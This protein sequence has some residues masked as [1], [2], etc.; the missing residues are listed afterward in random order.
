MAS[1]RGAEVLQAA[2]KVF[3]RHSYS[4]ASVQD[5]A[6]EL[7]MPKG[8]LYHYIKSKEDLLAKIFAWSRR[9]SED[10]MARVSAMEAAPLEK[11]KAFIEGY[12][13]WTVANLE[14]AVI[15]AREWRYSSG[16]VRDVV[17]EGRRT[18]DD[19][20][21]DLIEQAKKS[22][23]VDPR[24]DAKRAAFFLWGAI[25]ALPD[26]YRRDGHDPVERIAASYSALAVNVITGRVPEAIQFSPRKT[27]PT[28]KS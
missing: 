16:E 3:S 9:D 5:V 13:S 28:R 19:F 14:R 11:F 20:L 4:A 10:L 15:Y 21:I 12:V 7:N 2:I 1:G 18:L 24:L 23:D 25:S 17:I 6:D 27:R 26:W 8:T 22:G